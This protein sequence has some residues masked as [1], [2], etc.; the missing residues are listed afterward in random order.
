MSFRKNQKVSFR[1]SPGVVQAVDLTPGMVDVTYPSGITKRHRKEDLSLLARNNS[2][3]P[4]RS[5]GQS[6][7][8]ARSRARY[9]P[10]R[11]KAEAE[12]KA[13]AKA[14]VGRLA[15]KIKTAEKK[16]AKFQEYKVWSF[17]CTRVGG[18]SIS[19]WNQFFCFYFPTVGEMLCN[20]EFA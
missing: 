8:R 11:S 9:N 20:L 10:E 5:R 19:S 16:L 3:R 15:P 6:R 2:G 1:G 14:L 12:A 17:C 13:E 18:I 7:G 4:R